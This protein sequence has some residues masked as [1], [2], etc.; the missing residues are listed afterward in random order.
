MK[1]SAPAGRRAHHGVTPAPKNKGLHLC[2]PLVSLV[3]PA[4]IELATY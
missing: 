1:K 4:G 2:K 3:L